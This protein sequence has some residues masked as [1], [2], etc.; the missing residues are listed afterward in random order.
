[1]VFGHKVNEFDEPYDEKDRVPM[2]MGRQSWSIEY[3]QCAY[4]TYCGSEQKLAL[5][6]MRIPKSQK[7][8]DLAPW[9]KKFVC[10]VGTDLF[11]N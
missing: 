7:L 3:P 11:K 10:F 8:L 5:M 9:H 4:R 6:N 2:Q 1:M